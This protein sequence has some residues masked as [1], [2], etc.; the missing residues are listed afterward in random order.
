MLWYQ[1]GWCAEPPAEATISQASSPSANL[2]RVDCRF[3]PLLAPRVVRYSKSIPWN[4]SPDRRCQLVMSR[5]IVRD[6][7]LEPMPRGPRVPPGVF[8]KLI[9][10]AFRRTARPEAMLARLPGR[11]GD[12]VLGRA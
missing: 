8:W 12:A 5:I 4:L 3:S 10:V 11:S 1:A 9:A 6:T 2:V 7:A